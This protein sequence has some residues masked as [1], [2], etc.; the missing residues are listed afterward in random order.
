MGSK[1]SVVGLTQYVK[2]RGAFCWENHFL[3]AFVREIIRLHVFCLWQRSFEPLL[4]VLVFSR[5]QQTDIHT[6]TRRL[7]ESV[8]EYS[9]IT[10]YQ[11]K[12][13]PNAK[14]HT[15]K[16]EEEEQSEGGSSS[17]FY[18]FE[19]SSKYVRCLQYK[20]VSYNSSSTTSA[21]SYIPSFE[22]W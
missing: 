22:R 6:S 10:T 20:E 3:L 8:E 2:I 16:E 11:K 15:H 21:C 13:K 12:S 5:Q 1:K 19:V 4:H 18:F 14:K 17:S 7:Q 9:N